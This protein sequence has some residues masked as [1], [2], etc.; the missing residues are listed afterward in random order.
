MSAEVRGV[1]PVAGSRW[2]PLEVLRCDARRAKMGRRLHSLCGGRWR[3]CMYSLVFNLGTLLACGVLGYFLFRKR[4]GAS[5][6][7]H[8]TT[9]LDDSK[10]SSPVEE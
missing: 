1:N 2:G 5:N 7:I 4:P 10:E 9:R 3:G 8:E 6:Q